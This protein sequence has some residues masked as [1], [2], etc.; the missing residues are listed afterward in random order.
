METEEFYK[1]TAHHGHNLK[2]ERMRRGIKQEAMASLAGVSQSTIS[3]YEST[4][5]LDDDLLERFANAL[6]IPIE[7]LKNA[8]YESPSV[9]IENNTYNETNTNSDGGYSVSGSHYEDDGITNHHP[10]DKVTELFERL[11]KSEKDKFEIVEK[12]LS[13]IEEILKSKL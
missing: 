1:E 9:I 5:T 13:A 10:I 7:K 2:R 4:E 6:E 8:Q 12:R 11:L 3:K